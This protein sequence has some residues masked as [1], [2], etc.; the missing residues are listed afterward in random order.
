MRN[1]QARGRVA[2]LGAAASV[3]FTAA[4]AHAV[5]TLTVS[6]A[7]LEPGA[8]TQITVSLDDGGDEIAGTSN[9]IGFP[10]GITVGNCE[11]NE[12]IN[13]GGTSF[14][15]GNPFI[16]LVLALTNVDPIPNGAV[17]Y[18]CD[19]T[20][21]EGLADGEYTIDCDVP[22]ASDPD[23]NEIAAECVDGTVT[24]VGPPAGSIIV[25]DAE[26]LPGTTTSID[27]SL[28]VAEG[29][30]IVGTENVITFGTPGG[31]TAAVVQGA[32][33]GGVQ[34]LNCVVNEEINKGGTAFSFQ[35]SGCTA[36]TDCASVKA[37]VLSLTDVA[38]I[39][40]G[41]VMYTCDVA[42]SADAVEGE[43]YPLTCSE[44]GASD[45]EGG[46][47]RVDCVDGEVTILG[48]PTPTP[49]NTPEEPTVAPPTDTPTPGVT[50]TPTTRPTDTP[51]PS[52]DFDDDSCAI[53]APQS[54]STGWALLLP[55]AG[56]LWLRR[57]QK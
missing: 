40:D 18:T 25:G 26:G 37:L 7:E 33:A 19:V 46:E 17:M 9:E 20:A 1:V 23:G 51:R 43:T 16:A 44:A 8:T 13:K 28:D 11:V 2:L 34:L 52:L 15:D 56:L 47:L 49:T 36:G 24:V 14:T 32:N 57:R 39:P 54:T 50:D 30:T 3:L 22:A 45:A 10:D 21:E 35:P 4:S 55:L 6:D 5:A 12:E 53:V 48:V 27:V 38:P 29:Q 41:S 42:I 31:T